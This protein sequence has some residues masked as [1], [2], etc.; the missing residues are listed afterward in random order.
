[1]KIVVLQSSTPEGEAA[2]RVAG[3][4][5]RLRDGQVTLVRHVPVSGD[6]QNQRIPSAKAE[7]EV[8]QERLRQHGVVVDARVEF[9]P[10]TASAAVLRTARELGADLIVVGVRRRSPVGK[11]VLGSVAQEILL[12]ADQAVL[13][14]KAAKEP[15]T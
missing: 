5:A 3:D 15:G 1:M 8:A 2:L 11:L 6:G 12:H 9:G 10:Q 4:E 7:L 14:V 13:A